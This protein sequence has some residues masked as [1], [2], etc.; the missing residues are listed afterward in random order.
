[1]LET[2]RY[3]EA[4]ELLQFL[5]QCQGEDERNYEEWRALHEWLLSAFPALES[6]T[7]EAGRFYG[8]EDEEED[9]EGESEHDMARQHARAKAEVDS[10]YAKKLLD[11]LLADVTIDKKMLALEQLAFVEHPHINDTLIRWAE[12]V[13]LHP[14]VQLKVLQTLKHR[15]VTGQIRMRK[16]GEDVILNLEDT[17]LSYGDFD[18]SLHRVVD[19][20]R[21]TSEVQHPMLAYFAEEMWKEFLF[22]IYGTS[23]YALLHEEDEHTTAL[24]AAALHHAV[25]E[26]MTGKADS[27]ATM[28]LYGITESLQFRFEQ[29]YR[30]I[31]N[32]AATSFR[33]EGMP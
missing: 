10:Q 23:V 31:R 29:A 20:L 17:P 3:K 1:M 6:E 32:Y 2:E 18:P 25:L 15:N 26:A 11:T 9:E 30:F 21:E 28:E 27:E 24:W 19:L 8:E 12:H 13:D 22:Y 7:R 16:S 14:L 5:L 33:P 4:V